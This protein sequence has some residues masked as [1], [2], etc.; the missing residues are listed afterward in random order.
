[1][2][3]LPSMLLKKAE[4]YSIVIGCDDLSK[5]SAGAGVSDCNPFKMNV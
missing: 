4:N 1:M 5:R 2:F 3:K